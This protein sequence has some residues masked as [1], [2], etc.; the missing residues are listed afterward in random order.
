MAAT[1]VGFKCMM[2]VH[3]LVKRTAMVDVKV[4]IGSESNQQ[5]VTKNFTVSFW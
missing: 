3:G 5:F 4:F 2:V 1:D